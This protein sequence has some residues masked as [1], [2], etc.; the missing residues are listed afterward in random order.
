[1]RILLV[2]DDDDLREVMS[3]LL[4]AVGHEVCGVDGVAALEAQA[5]N[6][7]ASRISILDLNLGAGRPSGMDAYRWL[8]SRKYPGHI[9]FLTG[10]GRSFP[11]VEEARRLGD[12]SI[13]FLQKPIG[14]QVLQNVLHE[15][16]T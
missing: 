8:R 16:S 3:E 10:H 14:L 9:A 15:V 2:D 4:T 13:S 1:M 7:L 12:G 6:A 5:D 11:L